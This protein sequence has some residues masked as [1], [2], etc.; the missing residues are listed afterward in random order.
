MK[1][2]LPG[3]GR[4]GGSRREPLDG[5]RPGPVDRLVMRAPSIFR[6][7]LI[8]GAAVA[9]LALAGVTT[10]LAWRQ[11]TDNKQR[12]VS[13]LNA[14]VLLV[15]AVVNSSFDGA[16]STLDSI[17]ASPP[18]VDGRPAAT[19]QYLRRVHRNG[20][21]LF[22]GGLGVLDT[23]GEL[24]ASSQQG[25]PLN[26]SDRTYFRQVIATGKPYISA[27]LIGRR[28]NEP[29]VVVA[30]PIVAAGH[31]VSG[32]LTGSISLNT[33][34][35]G[36]QTASLGFE[37]L[38]IVDRDGRLL[39]SRLARV[40]DKALLTRL[41]RAPSGD[42]RETTGFEGESHHLVAFANAS[43]PGWTI[44]IDRKESG[45]YAVA[46]RSLILELASLGAAVGIVLL[47]LV[48][49]VRRSRRELEAQSEQARAWSRLTRTL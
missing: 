7:R 14:R 30:V 45:V 25:A 20:A 32:V 10:A 47:I 23:S 11:Y 26:L 9:V 12:A 43:T 49:I 27:G 40:K 4:L 1:V 31:H 2:K 17:A 3:L 48:L 18:V 38:T 36:R 13:D 42:V 24:V 21:E 5:D 6:R 16:V 41:E 19:G 46:R 35:Q 44:A 34:G 33:V 15:S 28:N 37:G 22:T 8:L 29:I 39:L